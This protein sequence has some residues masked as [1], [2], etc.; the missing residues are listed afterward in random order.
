MSYYRTEEDYWDAYYDA[1]DRAEKDAM[2]SAEMAADLWEFDSDAEREE[3]IDEYFK[4]EY[5]RLCDEYEKTL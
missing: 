5:E 2:I 3:Y 4:A 1:H